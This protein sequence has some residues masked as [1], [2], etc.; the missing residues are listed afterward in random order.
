MKVGGRGFGSGMIVR[1]LPG[2]RF[3]P[4][5]SLIYGISSFNFKVYTLLKVKYIEKQL[6]ICCRSQLCFSMS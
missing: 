1:G 4:L 5:K 2:P 3:R 6:E